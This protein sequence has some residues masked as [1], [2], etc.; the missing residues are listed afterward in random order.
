MI[1]GETFTYIY[2]LD[3]LLK[4]R[5]SRA[6]VGKVYNFYVYYLEL[7]SLKIPVGKCE[8]LFRLF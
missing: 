5:R 6:W 7:V 2:D 8:V 3:H 4:G 1:I